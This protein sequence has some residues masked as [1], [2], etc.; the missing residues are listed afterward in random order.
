VLGE[1]VKFVVPEKVKS[2]VDAGDTGAS[3]GIV[4]MLII[5]DRKSN[6]TGPQPFYPVFQGFSWGPFVALLMLLPITLRVLIPDPSNGILLL[7]VV[8]SVTNG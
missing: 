3:Q 8:P 7:L 5:E 1:I 6:A 4:M 2:N